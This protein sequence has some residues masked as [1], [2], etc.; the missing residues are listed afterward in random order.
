MAKIKY[1]ALVSEMRNKLNGSVLSK[2]RYGNYIRNKVTPVNPQT[3]YQLQQRANLSALSSGWRT[4]TQS[5]RDGWI[6][7][8]KSAS[9]TDIFG[10][11]KT[12]SGQAYYVSLNLNLLR[13]G[14]AQ[15]D[16]A[17][18]TESVPYLGITAMLYATVG[19][20]IDEV[21][22]TI[23]PTAI[24][25]GYKLI[26]YITPGLSP[27]IAFV[28]NQ[29]RYLG[30]FTVAAGKADISAAVESR[31]GVAIVG[32]NVFMRVALV[33]TTTGQLGLPAEGY[34]TVTD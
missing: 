21:S 3:S 15:I 31:F 22:V 23:A 28:K 26:V 17:P 11:S 25:A 5:Q 34:V 1:S 14:S 33:S 24:P 8:A 16:D 7:A 29:F 9:K 4:L 27:G 12:L 13:A 20:T 18:L 10:D 19:G 6:S 32:Q 2:N 30:T